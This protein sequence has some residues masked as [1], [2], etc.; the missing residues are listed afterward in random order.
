M[1]PANVWSTPETETP[2]EQAQAPELPHK[3]DPHNITDDELT[4]TKVSY[5]VDLSTASDEA[6]AAHP[7]AEF[8]PALNVLPESI[9]ETPAAHDTVSSMDTASPSEPQHE[10]VDSSPTDNQD[11]SDHGIDTQETSIQSNDDFDDDFD[12]NFDDFKEAEPK[13]TTDNDDD[14]F[15]DF[16]DDFADFEQGEEEPSSFTGHE[17]AATLPTGAAAIVAVPCLNEMDF[18]SS[19]HLQAS[20]EK[21]LTAHGEGDASTGSG[22][23]YTL[24]S[25]ANTQVTVNSQSESPRARKLTDVGES[26]EEDLEFDESPHMNMTNSDGSSSDSIQKKQ[27]EQDQNQ[28]EEGID[29]YTPLSYFTLRSKSLWDQLAA[30]P[31]TPSQAGTTVTD[32]KRSAIR[33]YFLVSL[34]VPVDLD[35]VMPQKGK[36]KRLILP[37]NNNEALEKSASSA[38][39]SASNRSGKSQNSS[40]GASRST[41]NTAR[42]DSEFSQDAESIAKWSRLANV[43]EIAINNMSGDELREYV[44]SIAL[45][46]DAAR[47]THSQWTARRDDALKDKGTFESVIESFVVYAQRVGKNAGPVGGSKSSSPALPTAADAGGPPGTAAFHRK[48]TSTLSRANSFLRRKKTDS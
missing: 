23:V 8:N 40:D 4:V 11:D 5:S 46:I 29:S 17:P 33:R 6:S 20:I 18:S 37:T 24:S 39:A 43:S 44:R 42:Q 28:N 26:D 36:Q 27:E 2:Q 48:T 13:P 25:A 15:G 47:T 16:D 21:I 31:N 41:K 32:W 12:D 10:E 22:F 45:A 19:A 3:E 14:D 9:Y 38:A 7:S 34:G 35:E 30:A 1:D